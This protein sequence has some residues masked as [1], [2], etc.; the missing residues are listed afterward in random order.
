MWNSDYSAIP[1]REIKSLQHIAGY[2]IH[3]FHKRFKFT[4]KQGDGNIRIRIAYQFFYNVKLIQ[5]ILKTLV[6]GRDRGGLWNLGTIFPECEKIL[7]SFTLQFQLVLK[8]SDLVQRKETNSI[9]MFQI[10]ILFVMILSQG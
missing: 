7:R 1:E 10:L 3:K 8:C 9:A 6:T 5:T 4:K 2:I